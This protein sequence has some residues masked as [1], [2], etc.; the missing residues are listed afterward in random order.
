[1]LGDM[2]VSGGY[3]ELEGHILN[4][5]AN[6]E[7]ELLGGYAEIDV[8]N[9]TDLDIKILGLDA[10]ARGKG[11]LIIRDKAQGSTDNPLVTTYVKDETV[12]P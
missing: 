7:I 2:R 3:I 8:N 11:T 4:T 10:S 6:S 5:N 1:M 12:F 9:H